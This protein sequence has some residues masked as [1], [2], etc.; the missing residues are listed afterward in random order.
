MATVTIKT[1]DGP[2]EVTV[3]DDCAPLAAQYQAREREQADSAWNL[4]DLGQWALDRAEALQR[5]KLMV[6]G[7][8]ITGRWAPAGS[9]FGKDPLKP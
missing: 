4:T 9:V 7:K 8:L 1:P 6:T 2:R 5:A 3:P